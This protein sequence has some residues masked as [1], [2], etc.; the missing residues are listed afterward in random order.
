MQHRW[1]EFLLNPMQL[2]SYTQWVYWRESP[3]RTPTIGCLGLDLIITNLLKIT[4][5]NRVLFEEPIISSYS[6]NPPPFME[7]ESSPSCSGKP[8]TG[9][10]HKPDESSLHLPKPFFK[11]NY[12][13]I[14][15][16]TPKSTKNYFLQIFRPTFCTHFM[17]LPC[18][19]HPT[20][21]PS[22]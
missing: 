14:L 9:P 20:H 13:V 11:I 21:N 5:W 18:M 7:S 17:S 2:S 10:N 1:R 15:S 4:P 6:R 8:A 19:P 22:L 3:N 16:C 12:N